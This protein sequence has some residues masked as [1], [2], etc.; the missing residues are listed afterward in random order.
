[1]TLYGWT[2]YQYALAKVRHTHVTGLELEP[3]LNGAVDLKVWWDSHYL[4]DP[5]DAALVMFDPAPEADWAWASKTFVA[6]AKEV[7]E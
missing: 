4:G 2:L 1:M 5:G 7:F 6:A 3:S